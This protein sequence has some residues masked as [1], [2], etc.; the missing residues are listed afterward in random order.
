MEIV[1]RAIDESKSSNEIVRISRIDA[2][3][4]QE[5]IL[6]ALFAE[7]EGDVEANGEHEYWGKDIDG[8][9]WR[10]HVVLAAKAVQS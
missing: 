7:C 3:K 8:A 1:N 6:A 4:S 9:T 2:G 10:V 5:A